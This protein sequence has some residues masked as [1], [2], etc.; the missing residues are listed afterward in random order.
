MSQN[1]ASAFIK[2]HI[3]SWPKTT[4]GNENRANYRVIRDLEKLL[5]LHLLVSHEFGRRILKGIL[6]HVGSSCCYRLFLLQVWASNS[7]RVTWGLKF[8]SIILRAKIIEL[9]YLVHTVK[10]DYSADYDPRKKLSFSLLFI[11]VYERNLFEQF[12]KR[13]LYR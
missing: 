12:M 3:T 10:N 1:V 2:S 13:K 8:W 4:T 11:A 6:L 9:H 5:S 7:L